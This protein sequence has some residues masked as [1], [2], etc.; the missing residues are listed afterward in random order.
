LLTSAATKPS[1]S[2]IVATAARLDA[3]SVT[4]S[5][6]SSQPSARSGSIAATFRALA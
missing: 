4:S 3:S 1:H 6:S 5:S 2:S